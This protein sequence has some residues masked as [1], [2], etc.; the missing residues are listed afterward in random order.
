MMIMDSLV[1][2][3][4]TQRGQDTLNRICDSAEK[5]FYEKGY[6]NTSIGDITYGAD[7]APGTFY[8]YFNDKISLYR[9][10]LLKL[11]H[12]IRKEI[13]LATKNC[14]TRY[15][16][17]YLGLKTYLI[18][19]KNRKSIYRIIWESLYVDFELFKEYYENFAKHYIKGLLMAENNS[20]IIEK[21]EPTST[22]YAL[23]G[24]STYVGLKYVIF[25]DQIPEDEIIENVMKIVKNGIFKS[26]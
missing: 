24:I 12:E 25:D 17:E 26:K 19:I 21:L 5:L 3:P 10:L 16:A 22:A 20:E 4:K 11:S 23:M 15:E 13:S 6:Y 8:I 9:Y 1:N 2:E 18:F 14:K 7:I